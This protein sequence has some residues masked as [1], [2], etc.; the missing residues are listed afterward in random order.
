MYKRSN[1]FPHSVPVV[2]DFIESLVGDAFRIPQILEPVVHVLDDDVKV[3]QI[4]IQDVVVDGFL[5]QPV[6]DGRHCLSYPHD[7]ASVGRNSIAQNL[8]VVWERSDSRCLFVEFIGVNVW[9]ALNLVRPHPE[10][11]TVRPTEVRRLKL[12]DRR[13]RWLIIVVIISLLIP[14]QA[15]TISLRR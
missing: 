5:C 4:L 14:C 1:L 11:V 7:K 13:D 15:G 6:G 2:A 12:G 9:H 10:P 8:F 3:R